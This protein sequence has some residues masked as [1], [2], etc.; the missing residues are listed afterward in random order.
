MGGHLEVLDPG[1]LG[2]GSSEV[3]LCTQEAHHDHTATATPRRARKASVL[4]PPIATNAPTSSGTIST[5]RSSKLDLIR[6]LLVQPD[7]ATISQLVVATGWQPH[8]VR[9]GMTGLRK[10][11]LVIDRTKG[12]DEDSRFKVTM[13]L[14][15]TF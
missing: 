10:Q 15:W 4:A 14:P 11:G 12:G 2:G 3:L 8:S 5:P 7:S 9:A 13:R 6:S 1:F